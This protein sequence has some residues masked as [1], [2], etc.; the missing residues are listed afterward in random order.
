MFISHDRI[1]KSLP[2]MLVLTLSGAG[3]DFM[4][5]RTR[6]LSLQVDRRALVV[7]YL[8]RERRFLARNIRDI[9]LKSIS[10]ANVFIGIAPLRGEEL[11]LRNPFCGAWLYCFLRT[12]WEAE[13]PVPPDSGSAS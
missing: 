5:L 8:N 11:K 4:I 1:E 3:F 9:R 12:W 2:L 10:G 13:V 7:R 6:P